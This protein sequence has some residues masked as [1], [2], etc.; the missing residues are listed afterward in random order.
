MIPVVEGYKDY[1][2]PRGV[3]RTIDRL[4][5]SLP[6]HYLSGLESV[7]LTNADA[8]GRGKT[9]RLGGRKHDLRDCRGFH[10]PQSANGKPWI[11]IIVD[12]TIADYPP[13]V[14]W[15]PLIR[16]VLFA[17]VVFHEVGHHLNA[18]VGLIARGEES[19]AERWGQRLGRS[20]LQKHYWYL[21]PFFWVYHTFFRK[22]VNRKMAAIEQE[23]AAGKKPAHEAKRSKAKAKRRPK[24]RRR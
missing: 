13:W 6:E 19:A 15:V 5:S 8:V 22:L 18:T 24:R 3:R 12:N 9:R 1:V 21:R 23:E 14:I 10:Y 20:Y 4:L 7:V 2:P 11:E 16:D 17:E